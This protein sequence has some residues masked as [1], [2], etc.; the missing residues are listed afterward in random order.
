MTNPILAAVL[1]L[2]TVKNQLPCLKITHRKLG[3]I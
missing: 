2:Y 3:D 1:W